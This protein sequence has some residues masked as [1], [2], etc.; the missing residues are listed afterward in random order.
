MKKTIILTENQIRKVINDI[1]LEANIDTP[2]TKDFNISDSFQSGTY[3]LNKTSDIDNAIN[4]IIK[5]FPNGA[6][7]SITVESS[8]S[9]VPNKTVINPNTKKPMN[10]G[11][12]SGLRLRV[13]KQYLESK[14]IPNITF[15][16]VDKGAQGP[17]WD[18]V[19][20][21][22]QKY[23]DWQYVKLK[24]NATGNDTGGGGGNIDCLSD[25]RITVDYRKEVKTVDGKTV[26]HQ[27]NDAIFMLTAN[28][29]PVKNLDRN[30]NFIDLNNRN[31]GR[32][33]YS[34][35]LITRDNAKEIL[36]I[37]NK[38]IKLIVYCMSNHDV[39]GCH[40]DPLLIG[41]KN[42]K[43]EVIMEPKYITIGQG[44]KY[45]GGKHIM[46]LDPCGK[47]L[48]AA[49]AKGDDVKNTDIKYDETVDSKSV[50]FELD[51]KKISSIAEVY[52]YVNKERGTI[53]IPPIS[54]RGYMNNFGK[55]WNNRLWSDF[56]YNQGISD[57][58]QKSLDDYM[59]IHPELYTKVKQEK[60][61]TK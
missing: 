32:N 48:S 13:V 41:I 30:D 11:E 14:K 42:G 54:Q 29:I 8:E 3:T 1:V 39:K 60:L 58:V 20:G 25:L 35:L 24:I 46:T 18:G 53:E 23:K 37:N 38:E 49:I 21:R 59:K 5:E 17:D 45:Q 27:C 16:Y 40:S 22:D 7:I 15:T 36:A 12:L 19:N 52:K 61:G 47:V 26:Q 43:G 50:Q 9:K 51:L 55:S 34:N 28:G 2:K 57:R 6:K 31:D 44:L 56:V 10:A 33:R 4:E